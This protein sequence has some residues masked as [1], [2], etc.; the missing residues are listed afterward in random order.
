[1]VKCML[2]PE[3]G[4]IKWSKNATVHISRWSVPVWDTPWLVLIPVIYIIK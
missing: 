2:P 4:I 1:M 3:E